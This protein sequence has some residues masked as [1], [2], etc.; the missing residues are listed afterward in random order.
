MCEE[1]ACLVPPLETGQN[2]QAET[3]RML[4]QLPMFCMPT[5]FSVS[6][7]TGVTIGVGHQN[8]S[9]GNGEA[10][11]GFHEDALSQ[12]ATGKAQLL[13][14][15]AL[16]LGLA[17]DCSEITILGYI[18]PAAELQLCIG[19]HRKGWLVSITL[20]AMAGG[21]L[22][23]GILGDHLG[24]RRALISALAVAALFSAV[25]SV[26]PTY[27]TF[28]T[29]RFCSGLGVSG[30]FPLTFS[31]LTETCSRSTRSRYAGVLHSFWPLGAIFTSILSHMTMPT[32]GADIVEDNSE[33]WSSWHKFLI[34][35]ILPE[36]ACIVGLIW[37]SES[38]RYLLEA[39]REVEA[40]AVYQRL[41]K[42][43]KART[44][45]GLTELELPG[46]AAYRDRPAS[47]SRNVI[48]HGLETF[49]QAF[50][51]V[52]SPTHFRTTLLLASLHFLLGFLYM[53]ISAFSSTIIKDLR[54]HE[55]F[56]HK[57]YVTNDNFSRIYVNHT[58][59][60]VEYR[61]TTFSNATFSHMNLNHVD[62]VNCTIEDSEFNSVKASVS[63]FK[64]TTIKDSRFIDT[65]LTDH[66][67]I[68]CNLINNTF[69]SLVSGCNVDFD[70]NIY[71]EDLYDETLAWAGFMF[72]SL[73]FMGFVLETATRPPV[74]TIACALTA[75]ASAGMFAAN[76]AFWVTTVELAV[77][78]LLAC[79]L[80]AVTMT[81]VE[82]YP[83]HL[84]LHSSGGQL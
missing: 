47:P 12:A 19:E 37:A 24:R 17:A 62:F 48:N 56:L 54:E 66:H 63:Y 59:E 8:L 1:S 16:G 50:Q 82:G 28:M 44:Q 67:F 26:M 9:S 79:A 71:L 45:Y 57:Q 81:V 70:Y 84:R 76:A 33:H 74:A 11:V 42:L 61:S 34:L 80:N 22:A 20:L 36:V 64:D 7:P 13:L 68:N 39:S 21:S 18:M 30:A 58:M 51:R 41:H 38:P 60:N 25:A 72:P 15:I 65:D 35:S 10:L 32:G 52:S 40:L 78:I 83:C 49:R 5:S 73:F 77:K 55:Y 27:G 31:Y 46:R 53:G 43:N 4:L 2:G 6:S 23:W 69:L 14:A 29:A 3:R 75:A